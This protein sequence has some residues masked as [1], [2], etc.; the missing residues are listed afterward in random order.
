MKKINEKQKLYSC[1]SLFHVGLWLVYNRCLLTDAGVPSEDVP[2]E[3]VEGEVSEATW[4]LAV[5][6]L[7]IEGTGDEKTQSKLGLASPLVS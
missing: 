4:D 7:P 6:V 1:N 2:V 5:E 3:D